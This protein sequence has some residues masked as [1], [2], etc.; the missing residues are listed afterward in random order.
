MTHHKAA[1]N[2]RAKVDV[3]GSSRAATCPGCGKPE[4]PSVEDGKLACR[5]CH[6]LLASQRQRIAEL[7]KLAAVRGPL[8][9]AKA[10]T[11]LS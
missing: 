2:P 9:P 1:R 5:A 8:T 10:R 3:L 11:V 6:D 4:P 7:R